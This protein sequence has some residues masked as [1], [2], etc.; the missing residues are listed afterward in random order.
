MN[1]YTLGRDH[2]IVWDGEQ[3][4]ICSCDTDSD[5]ERI[6]TALNLFAFVRDSEVDGVLTK[7]L[8]WAEEAERVLTACDI[9]M[10]TAAIHGLPQQLPPAYRDSWSEAHK[11]ARE[12]LAAINPAP[13]VQESRS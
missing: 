4:I 3:R 9:V 13:A 8:L 5:A 7:R 6:L 1:T 12:L 10:D 2:R 11:S